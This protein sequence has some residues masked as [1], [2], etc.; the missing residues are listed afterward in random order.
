MDEL[1][2]FMRGCKLK[3]SDEEIKEMFDEIDDD[4]S[5]TIDIDE[6][7]MLM[8]RKSITPNNEEELRAVFKVTNLCI[9]EYKINPNLTE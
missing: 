7:L 3:V 5:G 9:F 1:T 8:S 6:F 2:S 4:D